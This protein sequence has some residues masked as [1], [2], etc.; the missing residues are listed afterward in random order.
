MND[1]FSFQ[2]LACCIKWNCFGPNQR[3]SG[4]RCWIGR[5][6]CRWIVTVEINW[7]TTHFLKRNPIPLWLWWWR[8]RRCE[9]DF[10]PWFHEHRCVGRIQ[11]VCGK[12][13]K[14][15]YSF[16]FNCDGRVSY[17]SP[18]RRHLNE[19]LSKF[20]VKLIFHFT[21]P[22]CSLP[23]K[24]VQH[25]LH[26]KRWS[27]RCCHFRFQICGP[28]LSIINL[29]DFRVQRKIEVKMLSF[30]MIFL[31]PI[32]TLYFHQ[33]HRS[34]RSQR[35]FHVQVQTETDVVNFPLHLI[36]ATRKYIFTF[37]SFE[38][39]VWFWRLTLYTFK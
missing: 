6:I 30:L 7:Q 15:N 3:F 25:A 22:N 29:T 24:S 11:S 36:N 39:V 28:A 35:K 9:I 32:D 1:F 12:E 5:C 13:A 20:F 27:L 19:N 21:Q 38:A 14:E 23:L 16:N 34:Y 33:S 31:N 4:I 10:Q 37:I 17:F 18:F 8:Q 2:P 26:G